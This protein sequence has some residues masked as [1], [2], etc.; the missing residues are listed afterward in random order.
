MRGRGL[1]PVG[2]FGDARAMSVFSSGRD[3]VNVIGEDAPGG[4][5]NDEIV[6]VLVT[7]LCAVVDAREGIE[8]EADRVGIGREPAGRV[9]CERELVLV[10]ALDIARVRV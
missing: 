7:L 5:G 6:S 9:A 2:D 10:L 8:L 1:G 4:S 3:G